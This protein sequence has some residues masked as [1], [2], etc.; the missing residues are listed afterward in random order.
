[1]LLTRK[2]SAVTQKRALLVHR[3]DVR[4]FPEPMAPEPMA[5]TNKK[6]KS[7]VGNAN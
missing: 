6:K 5:F 1:M 2:V 7:E 3:L 4:P